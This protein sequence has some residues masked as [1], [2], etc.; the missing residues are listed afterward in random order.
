MPRE[1]EQHSA[2]QRALRC[3]TTMQHQQ[4]AFERISQCEFTDEQITTPTIDPPF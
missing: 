3:N 4:V 2:V 1:W